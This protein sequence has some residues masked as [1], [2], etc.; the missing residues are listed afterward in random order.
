MILRYG[1]NL[2]Q[3]MPLICRYRDFTFKIQVLDVIQTDM[4]PILKYL[5]I[6]EK[7]NQHP[8]HFHSKYHFI[9]HLLELFVPMIIFSFKL[10]VNKVEVQYDK[11]SKQVDVHALKQTLWNCIQQ[12]TETNQMV[13]MFPSHYTYACIYVFL[14]HCILA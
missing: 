6:R 14:S 5:G 11:S 13:S 8:H 10:Q 7:L 4:Q 2:S 12:P 9:Q 3:G 1:L